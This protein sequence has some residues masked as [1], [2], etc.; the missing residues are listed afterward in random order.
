MAAI[1]FVMATI[2]NAALLQAVRARSLWYWLVCGAALGAPLFY[3]L[4][5]PTSW[6]EIIQKSPDFGRIRALSSV[7]Q[8]HCP[9]GST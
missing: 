4:V 2:A 1:C 8:P 5:I 3:C 7:P 6:A 9:R